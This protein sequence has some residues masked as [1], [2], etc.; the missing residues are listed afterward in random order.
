[1][2]EKR[3]KSGVLVVT[4]PAE[5][6]RLIQRDVLRRASSARSHFHV[7]PV[8]DRTLDGVVFASRLEMRHYIGLVEQQRAGL[9]SNLRRQVKFELNIG[10]EHITNYVSDFVFY[11]NVLKK[12]IV[13][14]SKGKR[15]AL[16]IV[17]ARLMK[18]IYGIDVLE[19][20]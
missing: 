16:F 7:A 18:I 11:D 6:Q 13:A 1:M 15:T 2:K 10:S 9:I 20:T 12:E 4:D 3:N 5:A 19:L 8:E 14:D 17:K